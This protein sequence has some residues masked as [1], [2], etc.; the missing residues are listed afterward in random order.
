M[1]DVALIINLIVG[2]M[3]SA[4]ETSSW[5]ERAGL[6]VIERDP[7]ERFEGAVGHQSVNRD[8]P[9]MRHRAVTAYLTDQRFQAP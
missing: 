2:R 6:M 8:L 9:W 4:V 7:N 3:R 1:G 5:P